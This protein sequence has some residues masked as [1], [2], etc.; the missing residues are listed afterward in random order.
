MSGVNYNIYESNAALDNVTYEGVYG[1]MPSSMLMSKFEETNMEMEPAYDDYARSLLTDRSP[2]TNYLAH[3]E[4]RQRTGAVSG[5]LQLQYGGHRGEVYTPYRPEHFDGFGGPEDADPRGH[6]LEPDM[7]AYTAQ[8]DARM[9]FVRFTPE[10]DAQITGGG[11]SEVQTMADNQRIFRT[12]RDRLK[13]FDR[14]LDGRREGMR[15]GFA[16]KSTVGKHSG[17]VGSYGDLIKDQALTPQRRRAIICK[18]VLSNSCAFRDGMSDQDFVTA[19]YGQMRQRRAKGPTVSAAATAADGGATADW[20]DATST[21]CYKTAAIIMS[22]I[23]RNKQFIHD[24]AARGDI[25][26]A[27]ARDTMTRANAPLARDITVVMHAVDGDGNFAASSDSAHYKTPG[28]QRARH[29][30]RLMNLNHLTPAHHFLNAEIMYKSVQ[31]GADVGALR[32][33]AVTDAN[34]PLIRDEATRKGKE[35]QMRLVTG[36]KLNTAEDAE[37]A[38]DSAHTASYKTLIAKAAVAP[39]THQDSTGIM[40][41]SDAT[42]TGKT[43]SAQYRVTTTRDIVAAGPMGDNTYKERMTGGLGSKYMARYIDREESGNGLA[44]LS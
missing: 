26:M 14:Q 3:E 11:R 37:R 8:Q 13:V 16:H 19:K 44:G 28:M 34:T 22:D 17:L 15:R 29:L 41:D 31:P 5:K 2:D 33:R 24:C 32:K 38:E 43:S 4:P 7:K 42:Q 21:T 39:G 40:G 36:A 10:N 23:V 12:T 1:P 18:D 35:A 6:V 27:T 30:A 25:D 20:Q 9:R